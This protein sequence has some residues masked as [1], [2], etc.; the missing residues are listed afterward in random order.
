M[1]WHPTSK[2]IAQLT[3]SFFTSSTT[4]FELLFSKF[5]SNL[6]ES[7]LSMLNNFNEWV[8]EKVSSNIN[9]KTMSS[10]QESK[11]SLIGNA[12]AQGVT[13]TRTGSN[14]L[15]NLTSTLGGAS[16]TILSRH[17]LTITPSAT[18]DCR[19][20]IINLSQSR[21][22]QKKFWSAKAGGEIYCS[23]HKLRRHMQNSC[24]CISKVQEAKSALV[25][26]H[27]SFS[28]ELTIA[29]AKNRIFIN[30]NGY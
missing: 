11:V 12:A 7:V 17:T 6:T 13:I 23:K 25:H 1:S 16:L 9:E 27:Q 3:L 19:L 24:P 29:C 21:C 18:G 10:C 20:I 8:L 22:Q 5:E 15:P 4:S 2:W 30:D 14:R 28:R 26:M